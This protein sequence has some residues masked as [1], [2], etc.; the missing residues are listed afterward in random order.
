[1]NSF[2]RACIS[3]KRLPVK[4]MIL[5]LLIFLMGT[6][7]SGAL[8]AQNSINQIE[9]NLM[10]RLP[11]VAIPRW[12]FPHDP[13]WTEFFENPLTNETIQEIGALPEVATFD[14]TLSVYTFSNQLIP[15]HPMWSDIPHIDFFGATHPFELRGIN[16]ERVTEIESGML[17]LI[18][19]R[20]FTS[21][22]IKS[23]AQVAIVSRAFAEANEFSIGS[24]FEVVNLINDYYAMA[25]NSEEL[26]TALL[27][28][29]DEFIIAKQQLEFEIIGIFD[30]SSPLDTQDLNTFR[31]E[32]IEQIESM[33]YVPFQVADN[34]FE[35]RY[36]TLSLFFE[37]WL[38]KMGPMII[39]LIPQVP[40][41]DA[42][43]IID[44]PRNMENFLEQ[45]T[46]LLPEYWEFMSNQG[47]M[48]DILTSMTTMRNIAKG[49]Q[50]ASAGA[51]VFILTLV[52]WLFLYDRRKE[53]GVYMALGASR[54]NIIMQI[55]MEVGMIFLLAIG[56]SLM[57]GNFIG[58][59]ISHYLTTTNI[60]QGITVSSDWQPWEV[61]I[62]NA[63][64]FQSQQSLIMYDVSLNIWTILLV[65]ILGMVVML[66]ALSIS[67]LYVFKLKPKKLLM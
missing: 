16:N 29:L 7:L 55:S 6:V 49:I 62:I 53:I 30:F 35:F 60:V 27:R 48:L 3:I 24:T 54:K 22:E 45:A 1:M 17:N 59:M 33:I 40:L 42:V 34:I 56:L 28:H 20:T 12:T 39:E 10:R 66:L 57:M 14:L 32:G 63:T 51:L 36:A 50:W 23:D 18:D 58:H 37:E 26:F 44:D 31:R 21:N 25:V 67:M 15:I 13:L 61:E 5:F 4:S 11:S 41:L 9:D 52:I 19:G 2:K 46:P 64:W 65:V 43:F 38:E 47:L 8:L